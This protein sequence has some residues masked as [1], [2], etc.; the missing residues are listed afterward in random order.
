MV[1]APLSWVP[2]PFDPLNV[3]L[4]EIPHTTPD[5]LNRLCRF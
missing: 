5:L 1:V 3:A 2:Y 4:E